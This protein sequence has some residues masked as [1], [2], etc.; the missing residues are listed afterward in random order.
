VFAILYDNDHCVLC[1][2][3][4]QGCVA[5]DDYFVR[6]EALIFVRGEAPIFVGDTDY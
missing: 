1:L 6:G 4:S 2:Y 3:Y 5:Q